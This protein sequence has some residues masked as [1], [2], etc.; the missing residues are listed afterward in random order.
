MLKRCLEARSS[1]SSTNQRL[2][3][4]ALP[5]LVNIAAAAGTV[6]VP[7]QSIIDYVLAA[8]PK[9]TE[10]GC[11]IFLSQLEHFIAAY[12]AFGLIAVDRPHEVQTKTTKYLSLVT[13]VLRAHDSK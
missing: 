7:L 10:G 2:L 1:K 11:D 3:L 6:E 9:Y 5:R 13:H 4:E 8:A 12:L